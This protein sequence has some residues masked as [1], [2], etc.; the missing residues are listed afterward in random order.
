MERP[1]LTRRRSIHWYVLVENYSIEILQKRRLDQAFLS[2]HSVDPSLACSFFLLLTLLPPI[3][4]FY[5]TRH[6]S[7]S[8]S[9]SA[10]FGNSFNENSKIDRIS[11]PLSLF[12]LLLVLIFSNKR[13]SFSTFY[14]RNFLSKNSM[15]TYRQRDTVE[16]YFYVK[17]KKRKKTNP[18]SLEINTYASIK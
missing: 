3:A 5:F 10:S 17:A 16:K 7:L 1:L 11:P 6:K 18:H 14:H 13:F 12:S 4:V 15:I 9:S 8:S 2:F